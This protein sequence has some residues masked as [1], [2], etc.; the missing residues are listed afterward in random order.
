MTVAGAHFHLRRFWRD[1]RAVV[2]P[3][4][5]VLAVSLILTVGLA[6]DVSLYR[7]GNDDLRAATEAAALAAAMD[8]ARAETR[9]RDYLARNGYD[10]DVLQ[11][12]TIGRYCA[13]IGIPSDQRFDPGYSRCPGNGAPNAVRLRTS[14]PSR[15]FLTGALPDGV[16][17]PDLSA[18]VTA[19]RIDEAGVEISSGILTVTNSL[20]NSVNDLLGALLGI[21]LRLSTADIEALLGG[22]VDAG[23]FFDALASR[24]GHT[25]TYHELTQDS[26]GLQDIALAAADAAGDRVGDSG[27]NGAL[28][29][30]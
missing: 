26:Y 3:T 1:Q 23:L 24:T 27:A 17:I 2:G 7:R 19:T 20:V 14:K 12:V 6:L 21:K 9:A 16:L 30:I 5:A 15:R 25:G 11:S 28:G 29:G 18:T 22:N 10:P 13:D 4:V 8:P